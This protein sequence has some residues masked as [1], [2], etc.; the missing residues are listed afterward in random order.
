M[1]WPTDKHKNGWKEFPKAKERFYAPV[2]I[3]WTDKERREAEKAITEPG[4]LRQARERCTEIVN[5]MDLAND[6]IEQTVGEWPQSSPRDKET[7]CNRWFGDIASAVHNKTEVDAI[8]VRLLP[9]PT[10]P[11][12]L[13]AAT[14][15]QTVLTKADSAH[16]KYCPPTGPR[17]GP[18]KRFPS[19]A[20]CEDQYSATD[21]KQKA[22]EVNINPSGLSKNQLCAKLIKEGAI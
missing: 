14:A 6:V 19:I 4:E 16:N 15:S 8:T 22:R 18:P 11:V 10:P 3:K 20:E 12:C 2:I 17:T 13:D 21:L 1:V 5:D 7:T 9:T